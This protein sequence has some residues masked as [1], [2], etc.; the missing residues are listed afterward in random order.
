[1]TGKQDALAGLRQQRSEAIGDIVGGIG[2]IAGAA[3]NAK[4]LGV[5]GSNP[6]TN[7]TSTLIPLA[8]NPVVQTPQELFN[9]K[10]ENKLNIPGA[11]SL[12]G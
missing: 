10:E 11:G 8:G 1:M 9:V 7:N 12:F 4:S 3:F 2:T 6:V 5:F